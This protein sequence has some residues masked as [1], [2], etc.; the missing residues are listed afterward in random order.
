MAS[1]GL[2]LCLQAPDCSSFECELSP[3]GFWFWFQRSVP[4]SLHWSGLPVVVLRRRGKLTLRIL[5]SVN[6]FCKA[7]SSSPFLVPGSACKEL[8]LMLIALL[9]D[10]SIVLLINLVI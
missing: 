9:I 2:Q 1:P 5:F 8:L 6:R 4:Q 7:F 3:R 10:R